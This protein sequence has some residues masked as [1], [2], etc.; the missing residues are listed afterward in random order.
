MYGSSYTS[1]DGYERVGFP[2]IVFYGVDLV[3]RIL[4]ACARGLVQGIYHGSM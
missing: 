4:C 1:C 2:S 3:G